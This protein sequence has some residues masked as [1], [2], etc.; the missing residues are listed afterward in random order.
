MNRITFRKRP[1][2]DGNMRLAEGYDARRAGRNIAIIQRMRGE[3]SWFWYGD[4]LNT[5]SRP[6]T[7]AEA[8]AEIRAHFTKP[9]RSE[10]EGA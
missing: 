9:A 6:V 10:G 5:C 2:Y 4:G 7:L 1:R 8:K 3:D